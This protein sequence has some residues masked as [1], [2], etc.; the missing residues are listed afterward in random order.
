MDDNAATIPKQVKQDRDSTM[1]EDSARDPSE[2][3]RWKKST[4]AFTMLKAKTATTPILK[5]F[6]RIGSRWT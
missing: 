5:N 4:I 2:K 3:T 1:D 6:V